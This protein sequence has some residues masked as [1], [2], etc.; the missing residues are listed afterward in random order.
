MIMEEKF[1]PQESLMAI[2]SMIE[3]AKNHFSENGHLYLLWGWVV[4]ICSVAQFILMR[5]GYERHYQVWFFTWITVAYQIYYLKKEN[6]KQRVKTYADSMVGYVWLGFSIMMVVMIFM[7][8][9]K[10]TARE[11]FYSVFLALYGMP[12]FL[13][14]ALLKYR[15]L[16]IGGIGCWVLAVVSV[17][18][19]FDYQLLLISF[20]MIIAWII[21]GY[22]MRAKYKKQSIDY[23]R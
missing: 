20:A 18:I 2:H 22:L 10:E 17:F 14:G 3:K 7:L 5:L 15:P 4:F 8:I 1:S 11:L 6:K 21:P 19:P 13:C 23:G 12:T 9:K 16:M